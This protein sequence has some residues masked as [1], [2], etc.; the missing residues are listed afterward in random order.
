MVV[1]ILGGMGTYATVDFFKRLADSFPA[2]KEWERPRMIIDNHCT[3]PSRVR[4]LLYREKRKELVDDLVGSGERK[5]IFRVGPI[6]M[7]EANTHAE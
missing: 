6:D 3:M 5:M 2:E 1:G 4:A 7:L